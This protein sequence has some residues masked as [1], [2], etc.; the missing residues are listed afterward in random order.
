M[1]DNKVVSFDLVSEDTLSKSLSYMSKSLKQLEID[2]KNAQNE[3]NPLPNDKFAHT[4]AISFSWFLS[5]PQ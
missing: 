3:K 4:M 2:V 5:D 1:I